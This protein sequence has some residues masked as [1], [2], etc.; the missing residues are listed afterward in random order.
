MDFKKYLT[1]KPK[2]VE[3]H[4]LDF[5]EDMEAAWTRILEL[6]NTILKNDDYWHFFYEGKYSIIR[7][8]KKYKNNVEKHLNNNDIVYEYKGPWIDGSTYVEHHKQRFIHIFHEYSMLAIELDEDNFVSVADRVCHCFFNHCTYMAVSL[9]QK[10]GI[11]MWEGDIMGHLAISR[12]GYIGKIDTLQ[13]LG[14]RAKHDP[15]KLIQELKNI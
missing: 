4:L 12:A 15:D 1:R 5:N 11:N 13:G 10:Y 6:Y 8:S 9:R 7:C 3:F 2:I 14:R